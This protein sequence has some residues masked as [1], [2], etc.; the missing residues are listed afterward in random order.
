MPWLPAILHSR[1]LPK[2]L[3][4]NLQKMKREVCKVIFPQEIVHFGGVG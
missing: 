2:K 3:G 1:K 4:G